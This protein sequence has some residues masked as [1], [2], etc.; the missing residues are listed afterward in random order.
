MEDPTK[1]LKA[2]MNTPK[3][4]KPFEKKGEAEMD[5]E[6]RAVMAKNGRRL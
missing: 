4:A 2:A 1:N 6:Q 5:G 3:G